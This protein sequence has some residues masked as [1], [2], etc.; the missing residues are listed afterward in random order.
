MGSYQAHTIEYDT[1]HNIC[2]FPSKLLNPSEMRDDKPYTSISS[3]GQYKT[4]GQDTSHRGIPST[5]T[6]YHS[7]ILVYTPIQVEK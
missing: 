2:R 6:I 5:Q 3:R 1:V 7:M 4:D